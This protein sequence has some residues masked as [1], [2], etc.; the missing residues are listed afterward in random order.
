[1]SD[2]KASVNIE[3]VDRAATLEILD[4]GFQVVAQGF[5]T[6]EAEL[7]PGLYKARASVGGA[8]QEQLFAVE[9]GISPAPVRLD[10]VRFASPVP[11]NDTT[12][13]HEYHQAAV[14]EALYEPPLM[15]GHGAGLLLSLRDPSEAPFT[16]SPPTRPAYERSF[17]GFCLFDPAGNLLIDYDQAARRNP[18]Y[19]YAV[20]NAELNPG[21]YILRYLQDGRPTVS[22]PLLL[23]PGWATQVFILVEAQGEGELPMRPNL[24][25]CS[26]QMTPLGYSGYP[27]EAYFRMTE[28]ARQSLLQGRNIVEREVMNTLLH[29]KFGNPVLGLF[30]AHL[31]LLDAEPRLN[32]LHIVLGNLGAMLGAD[33]PDVLALRLHLHQIEHPDQPWPADQR[34]WFPTLLKAS[35]DILARQAAQ[36]DAFFPA[37]SLCRQMADRVV[38]NG[39]WLAWR[40]LSLSVRPGGLE[41]ISAEELQ[42]KKWSD[43][44]RILE[45][46]GRAEQ[47]IDGAHLFKAVKTLG[48]PVLREKLRQFLKSADVDPE[49]PEALRDLMVRL[50][51]NLPWEQIMA[52]FGALDEQGA[53]TERLSSVQKSLIPALLMLR[54]Q[55]Q[56]GQTPDKEQWAGFIASLQVPRGVLIENLRDLARLA[57]SLAARLIEE[58]RVRE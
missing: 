21:G 3:V 16:Q 7:A 5:G 26:V 39:V 34:A 33:F 32:L 18:E 6:L 49:A 47:G 45:V 58:G 10:P 40:P 56:A 9:E 1:M 53:I 36:D 42:S 54:Q 25:D 48:K 4:G 24:A 44:E 51:Q 20:R 46:F 8:V 15:L 13:S 35:W 12:T 31:L 57:G 43:R 27:R 37:D 17:D 2:F 50:A 19:G 38:D 11:L 30:A 52:R 14:A 23:V 41:E 28:I 55:V 29:D 22:R